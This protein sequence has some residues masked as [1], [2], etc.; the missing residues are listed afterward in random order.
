MG[1]KGIYLLFSSFPMI[2]DGGYG[3]VA[4]RCAGPEDWRRK[5]EQFQGPVFGCF[6]IARPLPFV[7]DSAAN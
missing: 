6:G 4:E 7:A 3:I 2:I 1:G 5:G